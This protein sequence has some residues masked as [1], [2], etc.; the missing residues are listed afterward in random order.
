[1]KKFLVLCLTIVLGLS[2][3]ACG[4]SGNEGISNDSTD[5]N[6]VANVVLSDFKAKDIAGNDVSKEVFKDSKVTVV[7]L[8]GTFCGPCID[9]M[10]DLQKFYDQYKT[11]GINVVGIVGDVKAGED[12]STAKEV[13]SQTGVKYTNILP[14]TILYKELVDKFPYVPATLLVDSEG[15]ILGSFIAGSTDQKGFE[16]LVKEYIN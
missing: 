14:D 1:M 4:N 13:I 9:E 7:N 6:P 12:T 10:P 15:K 16:N 11:K 5:K 2:I 8:W 3:V